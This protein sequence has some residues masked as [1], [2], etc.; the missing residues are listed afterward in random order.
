MLMKHKQKCGDD[1]TTTLRTSS[2]SY[3]HW[4]NHFHR[5]TLSFWIYADFEADNEVHNSKIGNKT[6]NNYRQ[7]QVLDGYH[8]ESELEHVLQSG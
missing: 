1:N 3:L 4:K 2:E 7:N 8:V 5:N 6:T